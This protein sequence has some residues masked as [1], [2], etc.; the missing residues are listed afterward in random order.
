MFCGSWLDTPSRGIEHPKFFETKNL[1][2]DSRL[3]EIDIN[4][5]LIDFGR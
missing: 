3:I 5:P 2:L 4:M 1:D